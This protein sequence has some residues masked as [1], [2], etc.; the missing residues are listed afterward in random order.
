MKPSD[1]LRKYAQFFVIATEDSKIFPS[2]KIAQAALETG[3][4]SHIVGNNLYGIKAT[5]NTTPYWNGDYVTAGTTEYTGGSYNPQQSK[6]RAY[7]SISDSI[8]DHN[9]LINSLSRY[10]PVREANTPED[11]ARALQSSG[12]ATDPNYANKLISIINSYN[13]KQYDKKKNMIKYFE[14]AAAI[15]AIVFSVWT[16]Y[17]A[18]K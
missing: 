11:Q 4:G 14:T 2:V 3:W 5:G 1:Y 16:I 13:L 15:I 18:W 10:K 7:Q 17:K 8:R 9:Y 12:Y 6:F